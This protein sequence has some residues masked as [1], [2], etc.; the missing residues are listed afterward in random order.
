MTN[1]LFCDNLA[2][3]IGSRMIE[4]MGENSATRVGISLAIMT[5]DSV[6]KVDHTRVGDSP[7]N[8][9]DE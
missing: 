2:L 1:K 9:Q 4:Q 6:E 8:K 7:E 3:K 5:W